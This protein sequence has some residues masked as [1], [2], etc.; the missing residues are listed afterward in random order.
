MKAG[1]KLV[2]KLGLSSGSF[3][4]HQ[5]AQP[6]RPEME[7]GGHVDGHRRSVRNLIERLRR[8]QH[9][10]QWLDRQIDSCHFSNLSGPRAGRA[11]QGPGHNSSLSRCHGG[12]ACCV[13]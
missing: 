5:Q 10:A 12:D 8:N 13:A 6:F 1:S 9:A 3:Q 4:G 11:D 7:S 2:L